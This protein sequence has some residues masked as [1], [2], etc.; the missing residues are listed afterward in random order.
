MDLIKGL[1]SHVSLP[2]HGF[3]FLLFRHP[4]PIFFIPAYA[5]RRDLFFDKFM[6]LYL[7]MKTDS[8]LYTL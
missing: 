3:C 4:I 6:L 1:N 7:L 2:K 5:G 8:S